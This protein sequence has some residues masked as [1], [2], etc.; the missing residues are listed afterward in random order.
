MRCRKARPRA[1]AL[2]ALWLRPALQLQLGWRRDTRSLHQT[3]GR[4]GAA[5]T[6]PPA[7]PWAPRA[8][9]SRGSHR[10][11]ARR[12]CPRRD[13]RARGRT[14]A[15]WAGTM[16]RLAAGR[17]RPTRQC[18]VSGG[19]PAVAAGRR[20]RG[21]GRRGPPWAGPGLGPRQLRRRT[22]ARASRSPGAG[23]C[24]PQPSVPQPVRRLHRARSLAPFHMA[25]PSPC[26][27]AALGHPLHRTGSMLGRAAA[28]G[29]GSRGA[30]LPARSWMRP[31]QPR[32]WPAGL[33]LRWRRSLP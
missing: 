3:S 31:C 21:G 2:P 30:R 6:T 28:P 18:R 27:R 8:L 20:P 5:A 17:T 15:R 10:P 4:R 12:P 7:W 19:R 11:G 14:V 25:A 26:R 1:S 23:R 13:R 29:R 9:R 33:R 32:R 24:P 16:H 22:A